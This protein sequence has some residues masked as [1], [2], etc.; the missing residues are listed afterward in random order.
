MPYTA[1]SEQ[2]RPGAAPVA[3]P[4][5]DCAATLEYNTRPVRGVDDRA[6][7]GPLRDAAG[8]DC[9]GS[10]PADR[11]A[12]AADARR[13]AT[14][15]WW[16][17]TTRPWTI[18]ARGACTSCSRSRWHGRPMRWRWCL[19]ISELTYRE[20]ER[21]CQSAGTLPAGTGSRTGDAG[22][23]LRGALAGDGGWHSGHPQGRRG[24]RA[25]GSRIIRRSGCSS[26]SVTRHVDL[27]S[28]SN[29]LL[30]RLPDTLPAG[31]LSGRRRGRSSRDGPRRIQRSDVGPDDLAYVMFTSGST[32]AAQRRGDAARCSGQPDR[33]ASARSAFEASRHARCSSP[34]AILTSLSGDADDMVLRRNAGPHFGAAHRDPGLLWKVIVESACSIGFS[35]PTWLC[36]SWPQFRRQDRGQSAR[37]RLGGRS[38]AVDARNPASGA[39]SRE[40]PFT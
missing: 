25:A 17:G 35:C 6:D 31:R 15:C 22:G 30:D 39:A 2:V 9:R 27:S 5:E 8:R 29:S 12:A 1:A 16:S 10:G 28:R 40:L 11:R 38:I 23:D 19:R 36:S 13:S 26:C 33:L 14:S 34:P 20:L 18:R 24:L 21:A 7:A 3:E 32:G 4:A 37:Y